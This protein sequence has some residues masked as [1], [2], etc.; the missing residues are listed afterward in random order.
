MR[1]LS[2]ACIVLLLSPIFS[3]I[4]YAALDDI[5][6]VAIEELTWP[7]VRDAIKAGKT[8]VILPVG[9]TEQNG[10]HMAIGKH[11]YIIKYTA[12]EVARRLGNALVAPI[13]TYVPEGDIDPPTEHM[14]FPG[15]ITLPHEYFLKLIE[16]AARSFKAH[17]FRDIVLIGDHGSYQKDLKTVADA[18]TTEWKAS[19][20]RVHFIPQYYSENGFTTWLQSQGASKDEI[21]PHASTTDTSQLLALDPKLVRMD[22]LG[23]FG[24][25]SGV[26]GDP[27]GANAALGRK[28]LEM[29]IEAALVNIRRAVSSSSQ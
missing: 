21:G 15:T 28:G 29:K 10:P 18:L 11:N 1:W 20:V 3:Q 5:P 6:P 8:T 9:G 24:P 19:G 2:S 25:E 12:D 17:G 22:K 7:E 4:A 26:Q 27:R 13:V 16:Y 14:R 23:E